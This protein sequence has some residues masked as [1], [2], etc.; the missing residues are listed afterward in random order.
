M[1]PPERTNIKTVVN[2]PNYRITTSGKVYSV[3]RKKTLTP[4]NINGYSV[5]RLYRQGKFR[6][7]MISTLVLEAFVGPCPRGYK[8]KHLNGDNADN[9]LENLE[10]RKYEKTVPETLPED[11][12]AAFDAFDHVVGKSG[13]LKKYWPL[14]TIVRCFPSVKTTKQAKQLV[15]DYNDSRTLTG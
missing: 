7:I 1:L 5:V 15:Q 14:K 10:W 13:G 9:R 8:C 6:S 2:F 3:Q 12:I 11:K 4:L